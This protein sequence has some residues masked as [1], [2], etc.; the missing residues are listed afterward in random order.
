ME[1]NDYWF[2]VGSGPSV[3]DLDLSRLHK[4][5]DKVI[6][7][8]N[9]YKLLPD[10]GYLYWGDVEWFDK[11]RDVCLRDYK[12]PHRYTSLLPDKQHMRK[13]YENLGITVVGRTR[14]RSTNDHSG[15][16]MKAPN[17]RG[18]CSGQ[19]A[20]NLA[21]HLG[22]RKIVLVGIDMKNGKTSHFD[23]HD[24]TVQPYIYDLVMVPAFNK[25]IEALVTVGAKIYKAS[26]QYPFPAAAYFDLSSW[27]E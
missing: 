18:A 1:R 27:V 22:A 6:V 16:E 3:N 7:V 10:A 15:L 14:N 26:P 5:L 2:I 4:H 8:N 21:Y 12:G 24:P 17:V 19:Q 23:R 25:G 11:N 20:M 13:E 9:S